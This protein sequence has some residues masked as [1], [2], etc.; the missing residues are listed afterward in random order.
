MEGVVDESGTANKYFKNWKYKDDIWAKTGT[1]QVTIGGIK[2]DLENNAWFCALTPYEKAEI[3]VICFVPNGYSGGEASL[4]AR[5]F[6]EWWMDEQ[7][8]DTGDTG[9]VAGNELMP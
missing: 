8:K 3:A 1:S 6:I 5:N 7:A 9:V 4:G 2:L